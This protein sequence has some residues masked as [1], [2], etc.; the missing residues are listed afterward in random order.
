MRTSLLHFRLTIDAVTA[1]RTIACALLAVLALG[2]AAAPAAAQTSP[3]NIVLVMT[4]DQRWDTLSAMPT[5]RKELAE[6]GVNF[7]NGFVVNSLCCPSRAS[8]LTGQYSHSSGVYTNTGNRGLWAFREH[9]TVA[10]ALQSVGYTTAYVGKYLNGYGGTRIPPGWSRWVAFSGVGYYDYSLNTD[11]VVT[12]PAPG[13]YSTD[14]LAGHAVSVIEQTPGPFFLV[15]APYAPHW[16]ANPPPRHEHA[17]AR[18]EPWR[19]PSYNEE[20]VSDKPAWVRALPPMGPD[21]QRDLDEFRRDQLRSLLSVD[22]GVAR[23]LGALEQT[24]RLANTLIVFTSDNGYAWGEHRRSTKM[25]PYEESI[26]VPFL[27]RYDA[28]GL[29]PRAERALALNIDLAPTFAQVAGAYLPLAD[30]QSL[31]PLLTTPG[32]PWRTDFLVEHLR[33]SATARM[34]TYCARRTTNSLYVSYE[35]GEE[36]FYDLVADPYQLRNV[37]ADPAARTA[38]AANRARL[39]QLCDPPPPTVCTLKGTKRADALYGT[40]GYDVVCAYHGDDFVAASDGNDVVLAGWGNDEVYGKLGNDR[41]EGGPGS[42]WLF[43]GAGDDTIYAKDGQ[44][45]LVSC[46]T[47]RDTV[48]ADRSDRVARGCERVKRS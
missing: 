35:T 43:G 31:V 32:L 4:D 25:D 23:I 1:P 16:P 19:P 46:W 5:V 22:E 6:K 18:L 3:P 17:F 12:D 7:T 41:L 15:F 28:L 33:A 29:L 48:V 38:L 40:P 24:G 11:G 37:A 42:D 14:V 27:V 26:R 2:V 8:I 39:K 47:G 36:E 34:P 30:G 45:D 21:Q 20:D 10:P 44:P 9:E 13:D